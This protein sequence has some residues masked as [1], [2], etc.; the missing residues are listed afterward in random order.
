MRINILHLYS[1]LVSSKLNH[2]PKGRKVV[3]RFLE[4]VI[5][6]KSTSV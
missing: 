3:D 4:I 6:K 1:G 2:I 5:Q